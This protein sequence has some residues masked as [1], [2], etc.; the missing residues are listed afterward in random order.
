MRNCGIKGMNPDKIFNIWHKV[1]LQQRPK[2]AGH[3]YPGISYLNGA[4]HPLQWCFQ[5]L[6]FILSA[7]RISSLSTN[8]YRILKSQQQYYHILNEA[9]QM[10]FLTSLTTITMHALA[11]YN[12]SSSRQSCKIVSSETAVI[13]I[14]KPLLLYHHA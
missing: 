14:F 12:T 5:C 3:P 10:V 6:F 2:S 4:S 9:A 11:A 8:L 1:G 7:R 13:L